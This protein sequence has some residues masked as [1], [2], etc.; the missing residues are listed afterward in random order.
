MAATT[1]FPQ[2][3]FDQLQQSPNCLWYIVSPSC[4]VLNYGWVNQSPMTMQWRDSNSQPYDYGTCILTAISYLLFSPFVS[5]R[6]LTCITN[7]GERLQMEI[8]GSIA[9]WSHNQLGQL[10]TGQTTDYVWH[11]ITHDC[12]PLVIAAEVLNMTIDL[13]A[14]DFCSYDNPRPLRS[15]A[16]SL[17]DL[18]AIPTF[19]ACNLVA[20]LVWLWLS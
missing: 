11:T 3:L 1:N 8:V 9:N 7:R 10:V 20:G 2:I 15:V 12:L 16:R 5:N 4:Q 19:F 6:T 17:Y 18:T 13:V 14:T